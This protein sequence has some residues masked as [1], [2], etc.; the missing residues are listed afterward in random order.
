VKLR[1]E[2]QA[3]VGDEELLGKADRGNA[4]RDSVAR[5]VLTLPG[6]DAALVGAKIE[7][8]ASFM[9]LYELR[10]EQ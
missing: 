10:L 8:S 9:I 7:K 1:D 6:D 4:Q 3:D 5:Q 2:C